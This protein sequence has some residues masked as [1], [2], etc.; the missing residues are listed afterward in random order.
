[1][2]RAGFYTQT[3]SYFIHNVQFD[4]LDN[5]VDNLDTEKDE[6]KLCYAS[7]VMLQNLQG[8]S[9][10]CRS[11][12]SFCQRSSAPPIEIPAL[13]DIYRK[14][15]CDKLD[16]GIISANM[17]TSDLW[18][19]AC[20]YALTHDRKDSLPPW[21][22]LSDYTLVTY[23]HT[24]HESCMPLRF[25]LHAS[26]FGDHSP[27]ELQT[28]RNYWAPWLSFQI[29]WHA[30]PCLL[31]H[32][33]LLSLRLRNF[34][35]TMP[36]SFLRNSFEQ[37]TLH[38]GWIIHFIEL[39]QLK[40]FE[41]SDPIIGHAVAIVGTIYLQHSF[42]EDPT[43][44]MKARKGFDTCLEFLKNFGKRWNHVDQMVIDFPS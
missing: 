40:E 17:Y 35:R 27:S 38:S 5:I 37:L 9:P 21:H 42:V 8:T 6:R 3:A 28:N 22:P 13:Q 29:I 44:S 20:Q 16:I 36:Q 30:V 32:P 18:S 26:R 33:F 25:R 24:E 10:S 23:R 4:N 7:V 41:V 34:R 14:P 1:M 2:I 11:G 39:I 31:N 15:N 43:F 12:S 19:F